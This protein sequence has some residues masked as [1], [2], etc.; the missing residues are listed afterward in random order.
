MLDLKDFKKK[1]CS[2]TDVL[3]CKQY[4]IDLLESIGELIDL[5]DDDGLSEEEKRAAIHYDITLTMEVMH[6]ELPDYGLLIDML[7]DLSDEDDGS[8]SSGNSGNEVYRKMLSSY[9]ESVGEDV[10]ERKK[11]REAFDELAKGLCSLPVKSVF[12]DIGKR[13]SILDFNMDL[14][15]GLSLSVAKP[16]C[17]DIDGVMY[18]VSVD[19]KILKIS[20]APL[21]DVIDS[22]KALC[23]WRD[24]LIGIGFSE[25]R[26]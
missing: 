19:H 23:D 11:Y 24:R 22:V 8:C 14:G 2:T 4:T 6:P 7:A 13:H 16:N 15:N 18:A 1:Y 12:V 5:D 17:E 26:Q 25:D 10:S 21:G 20:I 9:Y 3:S